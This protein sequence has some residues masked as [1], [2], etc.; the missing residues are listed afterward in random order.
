MITSS[1]SGPVDLST[2]DAGRSAAW[3][4][5]TTLFLALLAVG[6]QKLFGPS[7][8]TEALLNS[9]FFI[10]LTISTRNTFLKPYSRATRTTLTTVM[11]VAWY[12]FF[13]AVALLGRTI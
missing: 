4:L 11:C 2:A 9:G 5:G 1:R 12:A 8:G 3:M 6:L 13:L 10:A 7:V